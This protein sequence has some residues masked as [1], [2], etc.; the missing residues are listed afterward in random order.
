[1]KKIALIGSTGSIGRQAISVAERYPGRF[2]IVAMAANARRWTCHV[3]RRERAL[4][5]VRRRLKRRAPM[6][7][8]MS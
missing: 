1:M 6:R 3:F 4:R 8:R 5:A 7:T 2:R